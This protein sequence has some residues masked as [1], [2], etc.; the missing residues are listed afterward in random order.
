MFADSMKHGR[1]WISGLAILCLSAAMLGGPA[2]VWAQ[3]EEKPSAS[4]SVDFLT[5]YVWRGYGLSDDAKGMVIQPSLTVGYRGFSINI[6]GNLDTYDKNPVG[7]DDGVAWNETDFTFSY[8]REILNGLT[9]TVGI[10]Y[11]ALDKVDDSM[12]IYLGASYDLPWFKVGLTG[13]REISHYPGWWVQLDLTRNFALP[14]Y[15]MSIDVGTSWFYQD[16]DDSGAYPKPNQPEKAFS[17]FLSG[18]LSAALNIPV[19]QYFTISPRVGYAFPLSGRSKDLIESLSW[20]GDGDHVFGGIR[21]SAA[22]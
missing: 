6:W 12:E 8:S 11:Y 19:G 14:W 17:G 21:L 4:L 22:F 1:I 20:D 7:P 13:Y 16:S 2:S 5:Q 10:V 3:E 15:G 18:S 9:G